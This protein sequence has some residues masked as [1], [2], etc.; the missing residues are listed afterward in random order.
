LRLRPLHNFPTPSIDF[1]FNHVCIGHTYRFD[2]FLLL[3]L[4]PSSK[5][6]HWQLFHEVRLKI[7][8]NVNILVSL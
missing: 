5:P 2:F 7:F 8:I 1:Q 3:Q 6:S 4:R